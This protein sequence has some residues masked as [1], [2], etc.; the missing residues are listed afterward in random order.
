M[1]E[2]DTAA[3]VAFT[4]ITTMLGMLGDL[5]RQ[6]TLVS[7]VHLSFRRPYGRR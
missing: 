4:S 5:V 1:V 2:F 6:P 3:G 7:D